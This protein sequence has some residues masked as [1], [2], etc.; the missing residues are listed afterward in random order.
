MERIRDFNCSCN[1][2][3]L[4]IVHYIKFPLIIYIRTIEFHSSVKYPAVTKTKISRQPGYSGVRPSY[5]TSR[6][7][8]PNKT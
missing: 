2:N 8:V 1:C 4:M 5:L 7:T 3:F 6:L